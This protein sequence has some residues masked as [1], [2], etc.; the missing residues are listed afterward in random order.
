M[1]EK[2]LA[3]QT[4][5]ESYFWRSYFTIPSCKG[6]DNTMQVSPFVMYVCMYMYRFNE[7]YSG[8][9]KLGSKSAIT[10]KSLT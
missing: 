5:K 4:G 10:D 9:K 1:L 2:S 3:N 8:N 6:H 7:I